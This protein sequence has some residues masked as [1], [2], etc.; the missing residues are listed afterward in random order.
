MF[1][2]KIIP[3]SGMFEKHVN[4]PSPTGYSIL[5]FTI[6]QTPDKCFILLIIQSFILRSILNYFCSVWQLTF[7]IQF[8][9]R[10]LLKYE[11]TRSYCSTDKRVMLFFESSHKMSLFF[12]RWKQT[13]PRIAQLKDSLLVRTAKLSAQILLNSIQQLFV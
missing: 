3:L 9:D 11:F 10:F 8:F 7:D 4:C 2:E 12:R 5:D 13:L 1:A 6:N